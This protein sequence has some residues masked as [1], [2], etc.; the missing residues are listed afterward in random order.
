MNPTTISDL[1]GTGSPC[2]RR[3]HP[4]PQNRGTAAVPEGVEQVEQ[5]ISI[6][7]SIE[8]T[9]LESSSLCLRGEY[10]ANT[11]FHLFQGGRR[12]WS[13][14][15]FWNRVFSATPFHRREFEVLT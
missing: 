6:L 8:T 4:V 10:N 2:S 5:G 11:L 7:G 12:S 9:L 15:I 14:A 3:P 13:H 1:G